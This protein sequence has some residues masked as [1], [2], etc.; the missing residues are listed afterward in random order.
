MANVSI[1]P[2]SLLFRM[3]DIVGLIGSKEGGTVWVKITSE[4]ASIQII[5]FGI[6]L[7]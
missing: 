7:F 1:C 3:F 5:F 2:G 6:L 4:R